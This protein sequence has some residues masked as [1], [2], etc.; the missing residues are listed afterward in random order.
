MR[1]QP[2]RG[3]G[4]DRAAVFERE[5]GVLI[6]V[7]DGAGG[8]GNGE[9]AAKA[10]VDTAGTLAAADADWSI[11]LRQLDGDSYRL[12]GGQSTAVIATLTEQGIRGAS[13]GDSGAWLVRDG[14][15]I[16]PTH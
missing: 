1:I 8:T 12:D 2:I 6:A 16:D 4:Q 13:A 5:N 3:A 9:V 14:K 10:I 11:V 15:A 7:A